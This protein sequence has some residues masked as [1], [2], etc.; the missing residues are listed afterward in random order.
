MELL[1][2]DQSIAVY[3]KPCL[4]EARKQQDLLKLLSLHD[5]IEHLLAFMKDFW[6]DHSGARSQLTKK[7]PESVE[8]TK[9]IVEQSSRDEKYL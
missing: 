4:G 8:K 3:R 2:V 1:Y 5:K 9:K 7:G 6:K